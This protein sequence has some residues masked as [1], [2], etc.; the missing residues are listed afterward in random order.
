MATCSYHRYSAS[1]ELRHGLS[2]HHYPSPYLA[3]RR[4]KWP[5]L[6]H[7]LAMGS[8]SGMARARAQAPEMAL[9]P[10]SVPE[11]ERDSASEPGSVVALALASASA[12]REAAEHR[13]PFRLE[14]YTRPSAAPRR[15]HFRLNPFGR[16]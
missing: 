3:C 6:E 11:L 14:L 5:Q 7:G 1:S 16:P 10:G 15:R 13:R 2:T 8:A 12:V 9:A 4:C